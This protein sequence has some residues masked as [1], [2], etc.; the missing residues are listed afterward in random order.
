MLD[1][2]SSGLLG[3]GPLA[4][5]RLGRQSALSSADSVG[6]LSPAPAHEAFKWVLIRPA[7]RSAGAFALPLHLSI[8]KDKA[9]QNKV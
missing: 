1:L 9:K 6:V 3:K 2:A 4:L 8:G 5:C 7:G